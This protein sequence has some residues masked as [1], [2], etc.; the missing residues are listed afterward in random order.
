MLF[1][2]NAS[3]FADAFGERRINEQVPA[4]E[5]GEHGGIKACE[6]LKFTDIIT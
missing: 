6:T 5:F 4:C 1:P 2:E 3:A